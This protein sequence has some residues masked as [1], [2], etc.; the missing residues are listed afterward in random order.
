MPPRRELRRRTGDKQ[1]RRTI[2]IMCEGE[3]TEYL[4]FLALKR[5]YHLANTSMQSPPPETQGS[6]SLPPTQHLSFGYCC[7]FAIPRRRSLTIVSC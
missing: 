5:D 1:P 4:Y 3:A 7:T 2:L 6:I